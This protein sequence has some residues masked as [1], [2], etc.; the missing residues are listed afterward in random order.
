M[1]KEKGT[2]TLTTSQQRP[3]IVA[4]GDDI[5]ILITKENSRIKIVIEAPHEISIKRLTDLER[6]LNPKQVG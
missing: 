5:K 2:L 6:A 3:M 4:L 1:A